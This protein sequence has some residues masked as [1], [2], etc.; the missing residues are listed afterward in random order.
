MAPLELVTRLDEIGWFEHLPASERVRVLE[1]SKARDLSD[2]DDL[3]RLLANLVV[4]RR[5]VR[6]PDDATTLLREVLGRMVVELA[7]DRVSAEA[8]DDGSL[9]VALHFSSKTTPDESVHRCVLEDDDEDNDLHVL[10]F[11]SHMFQIER[12]IVGCYPLIEDDEQACYVI[13]SPAAWEQAVEAGLVQLSDDDWDDD[14][15]DEEL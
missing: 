2:P 9:T 14:D 11:L 13:V 5:A 4:P 6:T 7:P 8:D 1:E 15:G 3:A 12:P 10:D